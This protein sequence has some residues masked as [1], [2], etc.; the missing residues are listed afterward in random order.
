MTWWYSGLL[1]SK[2]LSPN[3]YF[4]LEFFQGHIRLK[5]WHRLYLYSSYLALCVALL[6]V[7]IRKVDILMTLIPK[8]QY[9]TT[10]RKTVTISFNSHWIYNGLLNYIIRIHI[11]ACVVYYKTIVHDRNILGS[12]FKF[13]LFHLN[14][15]AYNCQR[16][17][18]AA[19]L[20]L[21][22]TFLKKM[23]HPTRCTYLITWASF[24]INWT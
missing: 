18:Y 14:L 6:Q 12:L 22:Q 3:L 20:K 5:T 13:P 11:Q 23:Q 17:R 10:A 7:F 15:F 16:K 1:S 21:F 19:R 9:T 24:N 2:C 8:C 4:L